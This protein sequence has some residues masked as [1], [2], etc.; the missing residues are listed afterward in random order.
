MSWASWGALTCTTMC[1]SIRGEIAKRWIYESKLTWSWN[2]ISSCRLK[3]KFFS[4]TSSQVK[5]SSVL[6]PSRLHPCKYPNSVR[7]ALCSTVT[8]CTWTFVN[9][10]KNGDCLFCLP[11]PK[12]RDKSVSTEEDNAWKRKQGHIAKVAAY[13]HSVACDFDGNHFRLG[14]TAEHRRTSYSNDKEQIVRF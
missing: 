4:W 11:S 13:R 7:E 5:A 12:K 2:S 1:L 9:G 8:H 6:G 3:P 14:N 10:S